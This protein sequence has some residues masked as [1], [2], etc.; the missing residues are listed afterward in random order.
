MIKKF[1]LLFV[2]FLSTIF[3]DQTLFTKLDQYNLKDFNPAW[4]LTSLQLVSFET[5][6]K[7]TIKGML[8]EVLPDKVVFKDILKSSNIKND[9]K[10]YHDLKWF[11]N[12]FFK[13]DDY[14]WKFSLTPP[15]PVHRFYMLIF[16]KKEDKRVQA[17][18]ELKDIKDMLGDID[19][20]AKLALWL[21][22]TLDYHSYKCIK[23]FRKKDSKYLVTF[24]C[25][26]PYSCIYKKYVKAYD[27]NGYV[28][29]DWTIDEYK[30]KGC[31][32]AIPF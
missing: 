12:Y 10:R 5:T 31:Q 19:T 13:K 29:E 17:I 23:S 14:F 11:A 8:K 27:K 21:Y 18:T 25:T 22:A 26:N 9:K 15:L 30:E 32:K 6:T 7:E 24:E 28:R 2:T 20:K 16:T 3:A 1:L 4:K